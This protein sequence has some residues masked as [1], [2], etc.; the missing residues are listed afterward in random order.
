MPPPPLSATSPSPLRRLIQP[1]RRNAPQQSNVL[2]LRLHLR[3]PA[4]RR[5]RLILGLANPVFVVFV[6][7]PAGTFRAVAVRGLLEHPVELE[8]L[9][10]RRRVPRV[11]T[12]QDRAAELERLDEE[13]SHLRQW[14]ICLIRIHGD[15][16]TSLYNACVDRD[17]GRCI[18]SCTCTHIILPGGMVL[19]YHR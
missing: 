14:G 3:Q 1:R 19:E 6:V 2:R 13:L 17:M 8:L 11:R 7:F 18:R 15:T 16:S 12:L 4:I 9:R 10:I 5:P